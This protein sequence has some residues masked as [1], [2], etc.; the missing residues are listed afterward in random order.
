MTI[1]NAIYAG[2]SITKQWRT[3]II[4]QNIFKLETIHSCLSNCQHSSLSK[5]DR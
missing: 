3:T 1:E 5:K 4:D 2:N